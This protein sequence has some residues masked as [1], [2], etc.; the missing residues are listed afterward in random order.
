MRTMIKIA[1]KDTLA[2]KTLPIYQT[3]KAW[4]SFPLN[5]QPSSVIF[6][7]YTLQVC[8]CYP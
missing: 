3:R 5:T 4:V 2:R 1:S 7:F 6:F 8:N